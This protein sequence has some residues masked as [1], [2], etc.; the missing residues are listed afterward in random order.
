MCLNANSSM[1]NNSMC[2]SQFEGDYTFLSEY[3]ENRP[4][5]NWE[6]KETYKNYMY[7]IKIKI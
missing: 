4:R 6:I 1:C 5:D 7:N 3:T 2:L